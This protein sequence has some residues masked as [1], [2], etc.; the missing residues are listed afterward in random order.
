MNFKKQLGVARG[1]RVRLKKLATGETSGLKEEEGEARRGPLMK[2]LQALQ[3]VLYAEQKR[4]VLIVLQAMDAGGKDGTIQHVMSGVNPQGC[5]VTSFKPPS[6]LELA[7]DFLWRVHAAVPARGKIGIFNRSH[8]EDVLVSR[9]H[10]LVPKKV[11]GKRF[12]QINAFEELLAENGTTI[13][14]FFL[15]ISK[16]EQK[17]R[18]DDRLKDPQKYW[19]ASLADFKEREFWDEYQTAYED[20]LEKCSTEHA[21]W[22]IIPSDHKWFRDDAISE[23]LVDAL[24][25]MKLE[26]PKP[27]AD[28]LARVAAAK[29]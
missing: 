8:Y 19:K 12:A 1:S 17:R 5:T 20:V 15:H 21:P 23:I 2:R 25:R 4:S 28:V 27:T 7:H 26:Y 10:N 6:T 29:R 14:K 16:D 18:F 22:F 24:D 11:W 3:E 13:L 9:V